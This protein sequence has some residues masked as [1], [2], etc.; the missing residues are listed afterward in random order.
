MRHELLTPC[1]T[2]EKQEKQ[3]KTSNKRWH[4]KVRII[5]VRHALPN[6]CHTF[7]TKK[8]KQVKNKE[9]QVKQKMAFKGV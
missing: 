3:G 7:E 2:F 4:L 9:K 8:K 6:S 1:H 5:Q